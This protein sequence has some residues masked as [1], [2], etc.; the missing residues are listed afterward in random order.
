M[1]R[2][3][4]MFFYL[5]ILPP[6]IPLTRLSLSSNSIGTSTM[7]DDNAGH[8]SGPVI[9]SPFSY[10]DQAGYDPLQLVDSSTVPLPGYWRQ[11]NNLELLGQFTLISEF[12][13][14]DAGTTDAEEILTIVNNE[15]KTSHTIMVNKLPGQIPGKLYFGSVLTDKGLLIRFSDG[16][17]HYRSKSKGLVKFEADKFEAQASVYPTLCR[18]K[19]ASI[20]GGHFLAPVTYYD[21]QESTFA[22]CDHKGN[23]VEV[24]DRYT[25]P[26][27]PC[28]LHHSQIKP[29]FSGFSV[30]LG[31][32]VVLSSV[33]MQ[34]SLNSLVDGEH[35]VSPG[36]MDL[37]VLLRETF[38][39]AGAAEIREDLDPLGMSVSGQ[40]VAMLFQSPADTSAKWLLTYHLKARTAKIYPIMSSEV[41]AFTWEANQLASL[42]YP[43]NSGQRWL[44][45]YRY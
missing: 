25:F 42:T 34:L 6:G 24:L 43:D 10:I 9:P 13:L 3:Y 8:P 45:Y 18:C 21:A 7:L 22:I 32:H 35:A 41:F 2:A 17:I 33:A 30:P 19:W 38:Q 26:A 5:L 39:K 36:N 16:F 11:T 44:K 31:L 40:T 27:A 1:L 23:I 15:D 37:R 29:V 4:L 12:A 20:D 28:K 14:Q